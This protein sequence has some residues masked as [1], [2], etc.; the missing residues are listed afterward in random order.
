M[1]KLR[2]WQG[3]AVALIVI[4]IDQLS[5]TWAITHLQF[6]LN[7]GAS[8]GVGNSF[9]LLSL[10]ILAAI[11]IVG[12]CW[13]RQPNL[14]LALV[15]AGGISNLVDRIRWQGVVDWLIIPGTTIHNN[16]A[17]Y[18]IFIGLGWWAYTTF[19]HGDARGAAKNK[20]K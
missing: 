8:F 3:L 5:K 7:T 16:L 19:I 1:S 17:D 13:Y 15:W 2:Y 6:F 12:W 14:G 10:L 11:V 20:T 4:F 18:A 9:S